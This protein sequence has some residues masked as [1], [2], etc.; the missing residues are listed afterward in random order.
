MLV[1]SVVISVGVSA[2]VMS[3][4]LIPWFIRYF[5]RMGFVGKDMN[6]L[7]RPKIAEMGGV[8]IGAR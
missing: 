6:K 3:M 8:G 1:E 5:V 2:F 4:W 7:T